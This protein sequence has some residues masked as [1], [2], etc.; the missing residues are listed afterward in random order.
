MARYEPDKYIKADYIDNV[1]LYIH[2]NE[3][4]C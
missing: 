4:K 2:I 1:D 3:I